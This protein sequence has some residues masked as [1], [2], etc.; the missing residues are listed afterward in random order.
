[1]PPVVFKPTIPAGERP[2]TYALDRAANGTGSHLKLI[3]HQSSHLPSS[4][5]VFGEK[6][7]V[8]TYTTGYSSSFIACVHLFSVFK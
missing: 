2:H 3:I 6:D 7:R 4:I 1:M 5:R 8:P